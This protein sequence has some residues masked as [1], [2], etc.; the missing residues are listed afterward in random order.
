MMSSDAPQLFLPYSYQNMHYFGWMPLRWS[1]FPTLRKTVQFNNEAVGLALETTNENAYK[2]PRF[3]DEQQFKDNCRPKRIRTVFTLEQLNQLENF[4]Q[5]IAYPSKTERQRLCEELNLSDSRIQ[6]WFKN[7]RAK[8]RK[9]SRNRP[10]SSLDICE[11]YNLQSTIITTWKLDRS[12]RMPD[13]ITLAPNSSI[14]KSSNCVAKLHS[15]KRK[16]KET[17]DKSLPV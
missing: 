10:R 7:R 6:V 15:T 13:F 17:F 9:H 8:C 12:E 16:R 2:S 1:S 14:A 4:F 3:L 5:K 11:T